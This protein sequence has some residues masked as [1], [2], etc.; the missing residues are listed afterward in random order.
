MFRS[1]FVK[2]GGMAAAL[3]AG[4][5][6]AQG[7]VRISPATLPD[8]TVGAPYS[9]TLTASGCGPTCTWTF[10]G[11]LPTGLAQSS[12]TGAITG[13]PVV[14]GTFA[15]TVFAMDA[16][17]GQGAQPYSIAI[18]PRPAIQ[19]AS[20]PDGTAGAAYSQ[21]IRVSNGTPPYT[22]SVTSGSLP[23]GLVLNPSTGVISGTATRAGSYSFTAQA[24]DAAG[25][26]AAQAYVLTID[27][28]AITITSASPLPTG[29]AGKTY[30]QQLT[31]SGGV[32][33]LTWSIAA[34]APPGGISLNSSTGL[35]SGVPSTAG[36]SAFT[37]QVVDAGGV[38]ASKDFTISIVPNAPSLSITT[39]SPLPAG[40]AG[41]PYSLSLAASGGQPPYSW[42]V[43]AGA[44]PPGLALA[45]ATGAIS[46]TPTAAGSSTFTVQVTD[47]ASQ[48]ATQQFSVAISAAGNATLSLVGVPA[49]AASAQQIPI[50]IALSAP[51]TRTATGQISVAFQP[52]AAVNKDDPAIQFS[53]GGRTVNFSIPAGSVRAVFP[54]SSVALQTGTVAGTIRLTVTT[55]LPNGTAAASIAI[56]ETA[57]VISS[58]SV[59]KNTS[60]F[61][62]Q[63][64]GFSN[65]LELA[66]A[67]FHFTAQAGQIV[68]T[69][70]VTADLKSLASQWYGGSSSTPFGGQFLI[71][72]P[73]TVQQGA[74]SG[75]ASVSVQL[76]NAKG[77]S[78]A[79]AANF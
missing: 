35:L 23:A 64:A 34:G 7:A 8:W 62:V 33:P 6:S 3:W 24:A 11:T 50:D 67:S 69:S 63:I 52:A 49:S 18:H 40:T 55:D 22:F 42:A 75:L 27:P 13:T 71:V 73:F 76:Q 31:A 12:A 60:G 38:R 43:T 48:K 41:V 19:T 58:A 61:Q 26:A 53:T 32:P 57:P 28:P 44:L 16:H 79:A 39:A 54:A 17:G 9:Q 51:S 20:L 68:Q 56:G 21:T 45:A 14:A 59:T 30:S 1:A 4:F 10:S 70:D 77:A 36:S 29:T 72:V 74:A 25:A 46:G 78:A 15:F 5:G 65:S 37:V 47:S 66:S 2:V